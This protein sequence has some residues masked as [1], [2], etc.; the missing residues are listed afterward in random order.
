MSRTSRKTWQVK[1]DP[2]Q[3]SS[4]H[5]SGVNARDAMPNGGRLLWRLL[6][7]ISMRLRRKPCQ[8]EARPLRHARGF[9]HRW[10]G[11][12]DHRAHLR[13]LLHYKGNGRAPVWVSTVYGIV[14]Q[15]G[16]YIWCTASSARQHLKVYLPRVDGRGGTGVAQREPLPGGAETI[17][18]VEMKRRFAT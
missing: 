14:K 15:S 17:L 10:H 18:L 1:A 2:A 3:S 12:P 16:G 11:S 13:A 9:R 4:H 8:R 7:P 6:T 5:E